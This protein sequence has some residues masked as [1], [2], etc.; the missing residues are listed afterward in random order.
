MLKVNDRKRFLREVA[1]ALAITTL[2]EEDKQDIKNEKQLLFSKVK[3]LSEVLLLVQSEDDE[4]QFFDTYDSDDDDDPSFFRRLVKHRAIAKG[5]QP[6]EFCVNTAPVNRHDSM[7]DNLE[8]IAEVFVNV[9][10]ESSAPA[11]QTD[12]TARHTA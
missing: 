10:K 6:V 4:D 5:H 12:K 2:E 11:N 8:D 9:I 1:A 3:D 7:P